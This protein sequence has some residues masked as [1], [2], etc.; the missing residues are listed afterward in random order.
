MM[1]KLSTGVL[2]LCA[3]IVTGLLVRRELA[4]SEPSSLPVEAVRVSE[5]RDYAAAG[6]RMGSVDAPVTIVVFSDF[7][8]P[9]CRVLAERLRTV[10][11]E[12]GNDVVVVYRHY[13]LRSHPHARTAA[14]ASECAGRQGRFEA[15]H[16]ALFQ[17]QS[18]IGNRAWHEI[19]KDAGVGDLDLFGRCLQDAGMDSILARDAALAKRLGVEAT[20]TFLINDTRL[21][22]ALPLAMLNHHI[23]RAMRTRVARR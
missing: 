20:P 2:V 22:G 9:A 1:Q 6:T 23:E 21:V 3:L 4:P 10:R 14:R 15:M 18:S 8:C 7:Q 13:P 11:D 19:A 5:W 16:D 12:R 17:A